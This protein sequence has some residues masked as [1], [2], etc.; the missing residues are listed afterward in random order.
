MADIRRH[1]VIVYEQKIGR[2]TLHD[3]YTKFCTFEELL[4]VVEELYSDPFVTSV[5]YYEI[6][7]AE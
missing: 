5:M 2:E 3:E 6:M 1:Y 7:E 4:E